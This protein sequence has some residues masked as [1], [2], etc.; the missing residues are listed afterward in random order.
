MVTKLSFQICDKTKDYFDLYTTCS[1]R[2]S[3]AVN[4]RMRYMGS[5]VT[6]FSLKSTLSKHGSSPKLRI[7]PTSVKLFSLRLRA[8]REYILSSPAGKNRKLQ[9]E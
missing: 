6:A 7:E 9:A 8:I 5:L 2:S 3:N 1:A 4:T